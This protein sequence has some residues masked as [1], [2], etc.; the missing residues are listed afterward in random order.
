[1]IVQLTQNDRNLNI[2]LCVSIYSAFPDLGSIMGNLC[3]LFRTRIS[4]PSY[5]LSKNVSL[6]VIYLFVIYLASGLMDTIPIFLLRGGLS[7]GFAC[8]L[9]SNSFLHVSIR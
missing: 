1:M 8:F 3:I 5:R 4:R 7:S 9:S 6:F 2:L